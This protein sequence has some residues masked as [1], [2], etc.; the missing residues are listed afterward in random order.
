M[1]IHRSLVPSDKLKRH[2][3]VLS[4]A[5]RIQ[6]LEKE[7]RWSEGQSLFGLPKVRNIMV[8][9]KAK[10]KKAVEETAAEGT[11]AAPAGAEAGA[12]PAGKGAAAG[13]KAASPAEGKGSAKK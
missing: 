4:R 10:V 9:A 12:A 5:E 6:V 3:N 7:E 13:Q 1:S 2:R 8:K 11:E